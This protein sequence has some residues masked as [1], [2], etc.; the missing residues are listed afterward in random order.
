MS[1]IWVDL[2]GVPFRQTFYSAGGH[3]T[4]AIEC[5]EGPPLVFLHGTG[6][7]AE[8]YMRNL[9]AHGEHFHVYSI[10]MLGHG[11]TDRPDGEYDMLRWS[12]H[13][14]AFLDT[15]GADSACLS[16]ESLGAM[17]SAWT[18]I[19]EPSRVR[20]VV[21]NTGILAPPNE[22][23]K[24][25]LTDALERSKKAAG[26]LTREAVRARMAWLMAEPEK[27]LTDEIV[28]VRY[29]IYAQPGMQQVMGKIAMA[30]LGRVVDDA[31]CAQWMNP[32]LM[33][34]IRCPV[35]VLWTRHNPGQPVE[36]AQEAMR[37]IPD[38]RLVVLEQSAHWPQWEEPDEFN[39]LHLEFLRA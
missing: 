5:G 33:K 24:R 22:K 38:A 10:D 29:K 36:L 1:S 21:L 11:Y 37:H 16:G 12:D 4:R 39:R 14:L 27:T 6:G 3:R 32:E 20:K 30:T 25:E 2:M 15:I 31:F 28:D 34:D 7:H 17:V 26:N 35:L 23:G 9:A 13:L 19:R 18:A 8:A